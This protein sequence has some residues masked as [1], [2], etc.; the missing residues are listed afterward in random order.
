[1]LLFCSE[2]HVQLYIKI[3]GGNLIDIGDESKL[4]LDSSYQARQ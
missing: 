4:R 2:T 3:I 1:M